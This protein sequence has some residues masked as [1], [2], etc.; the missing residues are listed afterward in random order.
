MA[1]KA[2][3]L[4][5]EPRK[6]EL[7]LPILSICMVKQQYSQLAQG[8]VQVAAK[9]EQLPMFHVVPHRQRQVSPGSVTDVRMECEVWWLPAEV[10]L[11]LAEHRPLAAPGLLK[12][13]RRVTRQLG[14]AP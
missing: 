9:A 1:L 11:C 4:A 14:S 13:L 7:W 5:R 12:Q 6:P 8:S 10:E 3:P 2:S